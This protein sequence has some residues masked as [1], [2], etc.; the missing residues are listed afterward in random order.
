MGI[1]IYYLLFT[2]PLAIDFSLTYLCLFSVYF[3]QNQ[4]VEF[5]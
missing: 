3:A 2:R 4:Y 5:F 1:N